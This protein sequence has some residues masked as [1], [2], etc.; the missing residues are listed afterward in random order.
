MSPKCGR[1]ARRSPAA[2][3]KEFRS[4]FAGI[5]D[6]AVTFDVGRAVGGGF[7]RVWVDERFADRFPDPPAQPGS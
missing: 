5:P 6:D 3:F 4:T 7:F 1:A 2:Q